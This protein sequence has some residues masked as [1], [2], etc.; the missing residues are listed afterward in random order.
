MHQGAIRI[1]PV[2]FRN[3]VGQRHMAAFTVRPDDET[4]ELPFC[5][6]VHGANTERGG[7]QPVARGRRTTALNMAE[8]RDPRFR[9]GRLFYQFTYP[10]ADPAK[11]ETAIG[12][13]AADRFSIRQMRCFGDDHKREIPT[14]FA[15]VENFPGEAFGR[16]W[17]FRHQDGIGAA[18]DSRRQGDMPG[19]PAHDFQHHDPIMARR[20]RLET[21]KRL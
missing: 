10:L 19:T 9:P 20:R 4:V 1:D 7:K 13:P 8:H 5:D 12:T 11:R 14:V 21:I 2:A 3:P 6:Q 17:D 15:H 16:P 18:R